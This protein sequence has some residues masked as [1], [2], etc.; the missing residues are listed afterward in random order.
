MHRPL[1]APE[2]ALEL[3]PDI[4]LAAPRILV[5][6]DE[7]AVAMLIEDMV[8][9]L[10]FEV[11]GVVPRLEDAMPLWTATISTPPCWMSI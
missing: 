9:E 5:V 3:T 7:M 2:T 8:N 10:T 11:A 6:E 4:R 1:D